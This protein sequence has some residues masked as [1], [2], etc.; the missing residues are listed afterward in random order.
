MIF[1]PETNIIQFLDRS[2]SP[3]D[4]EIKLFSLYNENYDIACTSY[5]NSLWLYPSNGSLLYRI[6]NQANI[7]SKIE[8]LNQIT[9]EDFKAT[10]LIEYDKQFLIIGNINAITYKETFKLIGENRIWMGINMGRGISGFIVPEHYELYGTETK[11]N[12]N[13]EKIVSPNNCLWLTNLDNS[14]RH[15]D[16]PLTK[17]YQKEKDLYQHYDNYN[18]IN[19]NR[20]A[21]IPSDY[22]G[23]MGVPITFLHKHNPEQFE[24]VG[25]RKGDDGR[26]LSINGKNPYFRILIKHKR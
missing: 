18:G 6:D 4:Q 17:T 21:N 11:V 16:I 23:V 5:S 15:E 1:H 20:T 19:V 2:L 14:K 22:S 8:L 13:G 9:F 12:E 24:I 25:F 7:T 3:I 26:D 10:Q